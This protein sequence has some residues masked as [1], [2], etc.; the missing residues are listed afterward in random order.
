[1]TWRK[2]TLELEVT[3]VD[4]PFAINKETVEHGSKAGPIAGPVTGAQS[5]IMISD[6]MAT[7]EVGESL[8]I[9]LCP[10]TAS[11]ADRK[12]VVRNAH[13]HSSPK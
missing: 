3:F 8:T 2:H 7:C 13:A 1:M 4:Q 5:L 9:T 11:L 10:P 6:R 12:R